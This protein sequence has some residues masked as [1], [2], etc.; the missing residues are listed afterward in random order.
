MIKDSLS[1]VN[2]SLISLFSDAYTDVASNTNPGWSEVVT[3]ETHAS[4]SVK[5]T[6]NFLPFQLTSSIDITSKTTLHVDVW[7]A[8]LPSAGAGLLIKLLDAANGPHE[9]NYTHPKASLT[10][11]LNW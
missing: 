4:N 3:N 10:F 6:T 8:E 5:K 1:F 7:L 11:H 9:G 2:C